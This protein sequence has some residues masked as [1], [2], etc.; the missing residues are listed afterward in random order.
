MIVSANKFKW[1][2]FVDIKL[3]ADQLG[4]AKSHLRFLGSGAT[5]STFL[6]SSK[7]VLKIAKNSKGILD[8]KFEH[9]MSMDP[10]VQDIVAKVL[11]HNS[12]FTWIVSELVRPF[13]NATEFFDVT[14][15]HL[16]NL[17]VDDPYSIKRLRV[18][19][20]SSQDDIRNLNALIQDDDTSDSDRAEYQDELKDAIERRK[21]LEEEIDAIQAERSDPLF[22]EYQTAIRHAVDRF[23]FSID[24]SIF[25]RQWG[26]TPSRRAVML[27]YAWR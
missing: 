15:F 13:R 4:Y 12:K 8:N 14:G 16:D 17:M 7:N 26:Y 3:L 1:N 19:L 21:R 22:I 5:R 2:E 6:L 9:M 20:K 25:P 18:Y 27:D 10:K 11:Q 24:D 23:N